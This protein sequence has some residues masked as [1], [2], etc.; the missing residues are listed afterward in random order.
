MLIKEP[1]AL[2]ARVLKGLYFPR[3]ELHS[4][5]KG[6]RASWGWTSILDEQ[7]MLVREGMWKLRNDNSIQALADPWIYTKTGF[8]LTH[9]SNLL[10]DPTMTVADL[11]APDRTWDVDKLRHIAR[12]A[13]VA[14][15]LQIPIPPQ[16]QL[17]RLIWPYRE[18]GRTTLRSVYH[19]SR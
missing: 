6:G 4:S 11:I 3:C 16:G 15:I 7:D 10:T 12:P 13:N 17:D 14:N 8:K 9:N 19:R 2:W 1:N 5:K 18:D